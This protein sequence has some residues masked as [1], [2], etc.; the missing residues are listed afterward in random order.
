MEETVMTGD[1]IMINRLAYIAEEPQRG[2]IVAFYYPD[3]GETLYL[4]RVMGLPGETIEGIDGYVYINGVKME[5]DFTT[6][7]IEYDFAPFEVPKECKVKAVALNC[8][9]YSVTD[10]VV[11]K[12]PMKKD[13]LG[14]LPNEDPRLQVLDNITSEFPPSYVMTSTFDFLKDAAKPMYELLLSKGVEAEYHLYG[15]EETEYMGHVFHCNMNLEEAHICNADEC[16]FF[17][18]FIN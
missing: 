5:N 13:Y 3:D 2:D 17:K 10:D 11:C 14:K 1:R 15:T 6:E 8:G 4:K 9:L 18:Q 12:S 16:R 7:R